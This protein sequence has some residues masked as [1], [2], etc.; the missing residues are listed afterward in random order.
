MPTLTPFEQLLQAA[1]AQTEPQRLLFV[2]AAAQLPD[3]ASPAQRAQFEAGQGGAL[4]PLTCV[5]KGLS[6]VTS[7]EQLADESTYTTPAWRA[8]FIA[9]LSGQDGKPPSTALVDSAL[10]SM[11]A[12]V[13][14]GRL[15][16]FLALDR[17]GEQLH[18]S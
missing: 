17:A 9:G 1:A 10:E 2:F 8:V 16:G 12:S 6:E 4:V 11:V 18:F 7:F 3:D 14:A 15:G 5:D 13:R